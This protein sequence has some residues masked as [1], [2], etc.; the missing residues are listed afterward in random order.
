MHI[1]IRGSRSHFDGRGLVGSDPDESRFRA[2]SGWS[3]NRLRGVR[4]DVQVSRAS[5]HQDDLVATARWPVKPESALGI[6]ARDTA[7]QD[8]LA[9]KRLPLESLEELLVDAAQLFFL[10]ISCVRE[11][12]KDHAACGGRCEGRVA[13]GLRVGSLLS[14]R[15]RE[16]RG[17]RAANQG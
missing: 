9:R 6:H 4:D 7:T 14:P 2:A 16:L 5:A 12:D 1:P 3:A 15:C 11:D 17:V 13:Q 8:A 10:L